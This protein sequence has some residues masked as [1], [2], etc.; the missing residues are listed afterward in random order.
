MHVVT[1]GTCELVLLLISPF[2][3][4][5]LDKNVFNPVVVYSKSDL[6]AL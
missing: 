1:F 4:I 3:L 6:L 2:F 5:S